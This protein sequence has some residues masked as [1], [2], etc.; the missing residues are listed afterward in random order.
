MDRRTLFKLGGVALAAPYLGKVSVA[1]AKSQ[2]LLYDTHCHLISIDT[3]RYPRNGVSVGGNVQADTGGNRASATQE[4]FN[5][6]RPDPTVGDVLQWMGQNNVDAAVAVQK[7]GTYG[8]DN[9]YIL[10]SSDLIPDRFTAVAVV[11]SLAADTPAQVLK[12]AKEHNCAGIRV[13]GGQQPG[14]KFE[15][16][17]SDNAMKTWAAAHEAELTVDLMAVEQPPTYR[18]ETIKNLGDVAK[19]FPNA[20]LVINHMAW[21]D[22]TQKDFGMT[23]DLKRLAAMDNVYMKFTSINL[24]LLEAGNVNSAAFVRAT[25]DALGAENLMWGSDIGNSTGTYAELVAKMVDACSRLNR[26]EQESIL[27]D[28]GRKAYRRHG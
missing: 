19:R 21:P 4:S 16:L 27:S 1:E 12:M 10:D 14:S 9:S 7:K 23:D 8:W 11:D 5:S 26:K 3:N 15:W 28:S 25:V 22:F 2:V 18:T 20:R 17:L 24:S 13:T 6:V